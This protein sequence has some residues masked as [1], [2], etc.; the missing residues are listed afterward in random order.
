MTAVAFDYLLADGQ[1]NSGSGELIPLMQPLEHSEDSFE[2]LRV[3]SQSV[4]FYR[5]IPLLAAVPGSGNVYSRDA[6][7]LLFDGV[8]DKILKQLG[9][10][11][12]ISHDGGERIVRYYGTAFLDGAA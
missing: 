12:I 9:Q 3:N 11:H 5:K 6:G 2:I 4:V 1:S 8:A 7:F 10:L